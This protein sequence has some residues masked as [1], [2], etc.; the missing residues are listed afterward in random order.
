[1]FFVLSVQGACDGQQAG[2]EN[3]EEAKGSGY[4]GRGR[5]ETRRP[6]QRA[7]TLF[8]TLYTCVCVCFHMV[9]K[10][11]NFLFIISI[12]IYVVCKSVKV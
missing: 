4:A 3:R 5:E 10:L 11:I 7:G 2:E 1:M 8:Y 9:Y 12:S 6:V